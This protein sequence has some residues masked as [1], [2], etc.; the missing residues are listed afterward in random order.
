[1]VFPWISMGYPMDFL[2]YW[3]WI[4]HGVPWDTGPQIFH[5]KPMEYFCWGQ[6]I[7][8]Q[9]SWPVVPLHFTYSNSL[10]TSMFLFLVYFNTIRSCSHCSCSYLSLRHNRWNSMTLLLLINFV[11]LL[12]C[13][14]TTED[15]WFQNS[16]YK[17]PMQA[18]KSI[19]NNP[20]C[21]KWYQAIQYIC[22]KECR[23][24]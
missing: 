8:V 16:E 24:S 19:H 4:L 18:H 13:N 2:W 14:F 17:K 6:L 5:G 12:G 9:I 1:M 11:R 10:S 7:F 15:T 21:Y 22:C 3:P 23:K 20:G